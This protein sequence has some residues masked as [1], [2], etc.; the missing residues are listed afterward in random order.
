MSRR[1]KA[2][3]ERAKK[4]KRKDKASKAGKPS[5]KFAIKDQIVDFIRRQPE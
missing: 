5:S 2:K 1:E 3:R 4:D